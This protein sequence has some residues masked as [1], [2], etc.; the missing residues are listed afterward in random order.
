MNMISNSSVA[1][2]P[3]RKVYLGFLIL[4]ECT[5]SSY[6]HWL[7]ELFFFFKAW[8]NVCFENTKIKSHWISPTSLL[9]DRGQLTTLFGIQYLH[10]SN[11][12]VN[13]HRIQLV[14]SDRCQIQLAYG[15]NHHLS[16]HVNCGV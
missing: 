13:G 6:Q 9:C 11:E 7:P 1:K 8:P 3:P 15:N 5:I 4:L 10:L 16:V 2:M 14:A 12:G